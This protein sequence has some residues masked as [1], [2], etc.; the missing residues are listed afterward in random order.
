MIRAYTIV[1]PAEFRDFENFLFSYPNHHTLEFDFPSDI[2][3]ID[4]IDYRIST[5]ET[6]L[7]IPI[8]GDGSSTVDF[9]E[10]SDYIFTDIDDSAT[11]QYFGAIKN[12]NDKT[13][14]LNVK[15]SEILY[16]VG[17][18][19]NYAIDWNNRATLTYL[20]PNEVEL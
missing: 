8:T 14:F 7:P 9:A 15:N 20:K 10:L 5:I 17:I 6:E 12:S 18:V 2:V 1:N 4:S 19:A 16:Y 13:L 11:P 3:K